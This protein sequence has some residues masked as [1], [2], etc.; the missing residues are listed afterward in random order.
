MTRAMA[1]LVPL[2]SM[3]GELLNSYLYSLGIPPK[4]QFDGNSLRGNFTLKCEK[5]QR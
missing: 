2:W 3:H 4:V 1:D 5:V